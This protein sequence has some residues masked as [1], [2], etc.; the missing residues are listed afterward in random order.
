MTGTT[1]N[2]FV[3]FDNLNDD[4]KLKIIENMSSSKD[5][6]NFMASGVSGQPKLQVKHKLKALQRES[7]HKLINTL[8]R[9]THA[10]VGAE[11]QFLKDE[12]LRNRHLDMFING[13]TH[14][15]LLENDESFKQYNNTFQDLLD[16]LSHE[17]INPMELYT[18]YEKRRLLAEI[19]NR[20]RLRK[21]L[22]ETAKRMLFK[23]VEDDAIEHKLYIQFES[24][25]SVSIIILLSNQADS[26][27]PYID[28]EAQFYV[29]HK[30]K[31]YKTKY[32]ISDED[33]EEDEEGIIT[34]VRI[35]ND[36]VGWIVPF[37]LTL[38]KTIGKK[39]VLGQVKNMDYAYTG[40]QFWLKAYMLLEV[41]PK[42]I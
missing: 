17:V 24:G 21:D 15:T 34:T 3:L 18:E 13:Y 26:T 42:L 4:L 16:D 8:Y 37:L 32:V 22:N 20:L 25:V 31:S 5:L 29:K 36:P 33:E 38:L 39:F 14:T 12:E 1:M 9:F 11:K 40:D 23:T 10:C 35:K 41:L 30:N 27:V 19:M 2:E 7:F 28:V 6:L